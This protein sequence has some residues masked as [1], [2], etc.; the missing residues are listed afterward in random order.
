MPEEIKPEELSVPATRRGA[1][2]R[3]AEGERGGGRVVLPRPPGPVLVTGANGYVA[4]WLVKRLLE[5]GCDVRATVR[6]P[7]D[8]AKTA[9]LRAVAHACPGTLT[10]FRADLLDPGG[11]GRAMAGCALVFHT[12][13][14]LIV[15]EA[16]DPV[17]DLIEPATRGT[18]HVLEAASRTPSVRRVVLTSS[19]VA[20]YGDAADLA[21]I[22]EDR[23]DESHWNRSSGEHHQPY[24]Y[25]KTLAERLAWK[26][27]G[28]QDRWDLV[29][30]NP[31]LV[32]GPGLSPHTRSEGVL[33]MRDLGNGY[34]RFGAPELELAIVDVRDVAEGHLR[35]GLIPEAGGRHILVSET[36]GLIEIA[37]TLR[38]HFG[39]GFPFPRRTVSKPVAYMLAPRRGIPQSVAKRNIG[40]SLR[41]DN[42]RARE[43]LGM[44]FRPA[45]ESVT[46]HFRQLLDDGL[47][48]RAAARP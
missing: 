4:S 42:H 21:E 20:V 22:E 18:R 2:R 7:G 35:A 48:L 9:H 24:S 34:Y 13:S 12:A 40:Y 10:L 38:A 46:S 23:F 33:I 41:F 29:V 45:A 25:S 31:G 5:A 8:P 3:S 27:A 28:D 43:A 17:R 1:R 15:R 14:P 19:I 47:V 32:L 37:E 11:F 16:V 26:I 6:D 36:L 30:V 44:E 39:G